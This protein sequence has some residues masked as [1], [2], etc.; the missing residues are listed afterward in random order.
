MWRRPTGLAWTESDDGETAY[1]TSTARGRIVVLSYIAATIW[2]CADRASTID[3]IIGR[4]S[5]HFE[6]D[7]DTVRDDVRQCVTDLVNAG[8]L[9]LEG[10]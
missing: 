3:E 7:R 1:V 2:Q 6:I 4:L 5:A 10:N 9:E 8:L